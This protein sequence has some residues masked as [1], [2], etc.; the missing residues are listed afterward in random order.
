MN[1]YCNFWGNP[2]IHE[3]AKIGAFVEIGS[4]EGFETHIGKC[5]IEAYVFIPP[6][7]TIEDD[8]FIGPSVMFANDKHPGMSWE[9]RPMKRTLVKKGA[10]IGMGALIGPGITIGENAV[11]GMGAVVLKDVPDNTT[12]VGNPAKPINL[13]QQNKPKE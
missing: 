5:K 7:I 11:I 8:V 2:K 3:E 12:V 13:C 4:Y 6:G 1:P 9:G 10:V